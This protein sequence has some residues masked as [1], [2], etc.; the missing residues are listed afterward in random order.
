MIRYKDALQWEDKTVAYFVKA[1]HTGHRKHQCGQFIFQNIHDEIGFGECSRASHIDYVC[2]VPSIVDV[3]KTKNVMQL[4]TPSKFSRLPIANVQCPE[5]HLTHVFLACDALS[6]CFSLGDPST[7]SPCDNSKE[8]F[9]N[10][11]VC[12]NEIQDVPYTLVCNHHPDCGDK[13]DE[14]FCIFLTCDD[15]H[16]HRCPNYQVYCF[17]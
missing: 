5:G 4:D 14:E 16:P 17:W 11:F 1:H 15:R 6:S 8:T 12:D 2:E 10:M 13:S 3:A 9:Q 7:D